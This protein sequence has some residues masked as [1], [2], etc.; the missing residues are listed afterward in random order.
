[1]SIPCLHTTAVIS[2]CQN[3]DFICKLQYF[4]IYAFLLFV[5]F[6]VLIFTRAND[7]KFYKRILFFKDN[8]TCA[9]IVS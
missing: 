2:I 8:I 1:M 3:N 5:P 4:F 6:Y 7:D 9:A